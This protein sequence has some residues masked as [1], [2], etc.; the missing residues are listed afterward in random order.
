MSDEL[1]EVEVWEREV[2]AASEALAS[3]IG[4]RGERAVEARRDQ[5]QRYARARRRLERAQAA[6]PDPAAS[7]SSNTAL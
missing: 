4:D 2:N 1:Y 7:P 5:I 6:V 3:G